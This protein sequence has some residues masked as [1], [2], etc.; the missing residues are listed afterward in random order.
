MPWKMIGLIVLLV[1]FAAFATLNISNRADISLGLYVFEEVP[2]FLSLLVA[3]LA[4][5]V[6]MIPFTFGP[7]VRKMR[8]KKEKQ[9][10]KKAKEDAKK[11]K[12]AAKAHRLETKA[13]SKLAKE[14]KKE[15][16][17]AISLPDAPGVAAGPAPLDSPETSLSAG[18]KADNEK[19]AKKKKKK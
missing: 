1:L 7:S 4:G 12:E 18:G 9:E 5:A 14:M 19:D 8:V 16:A 17:A 15:K 6:A 10:A 2:I 13:E 3:F 11:Q